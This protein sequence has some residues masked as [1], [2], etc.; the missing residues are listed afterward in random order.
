MNRQ[1]P[2]FLV[3]LIFPTMLTA[4]WVQLPGPYGGIVQAL[5]E[6]ADGTLLS[7]Q[8]AGPLYM[9]SDDGRNWSVVVKDSW[10]E[11]IVLFA[12]APNGTVFAGEYHGL[13]RSAD[14]RTW[15][16]LDLQDV[17]A[18]IAFATNED[19]LVGGIGAIHRSSDD[20][21]NWKTLTPIPAS[22][23]MFRI[24]VTGSGA[25]LAGAYRE[26]IL[27][28]TDEGG[29]WETTGASLPNNEVYSLSTVDGDI[30]F[31]GLNNTTWF[32]I[33]DGETWSE[34]S[35][36]V[37]VNVYR[38]W[39]LS[40]NRLGAGS[41]GGLFISADDGRN[42]VRS[43]GET[44]HNQLSA[45]HVTPAGLLLAAANGTVLRSTD[46]GDSWESSVEGIHVTDITA[47]CFPNDDVY[48]AGTMYCDIHRATDGGHT[49]HLADTV[50]RAFS[51]ADLIA[52]TRAVHAATIDMGFR[53]STDAGETW[54]TIPSP[55]ENFSGTALTETATGLLAA[56][57]DGTCFHTT[58]QGTSWE[59][60]GTIM[61]F[62][63]TVNRV[64]LLSDINEANRIYAGTDRGLYRSTDAGETWIRFPLPGA[65]TDILFLHQSPDASLF[66]WSGK[67]LFRSGDLGESWTEIYE[68][69]ELPW[70]PLITTN[71]R[72]NVFVTDAEGIAHSADGIDGWERLNVPHRIT[73]L[74]VDRDGYLLIGTESDGLYRSEETTVGIPDITSMPNGLHIDGVYPQPLRAGAAGTLRVTMKRDAVVTLQ[75]FD[76]LGNMVIEQS[77][78]R[79]AAGSQ[80]FSL[81]ADGLVPG[82]YTVRVTAGM[83][84]A[85]RKLLI[86]D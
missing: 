66:A 47:L 86:L 70:R 68:T 9:S 29:S 82:V 64:R 60:R 73:A 57:Y 34:A 46:H 18:S 85:E 2:F 62:S 21:D 51:T 45:V 15:E 23:R 39:R 55:E 74:A 84:R 80:G 17:P 48:L 49:W 81:N 72:G 31:A 42:W 65:S 83:E 20:G 7:A 44:I 59:Q 11:N 40:G 30:V 33:D 13:H 58:D 67:K 79:I 6:T 3:M 22:K 52:G 77:P 50:F 5:G 12:T 4:Q 78:R 1:I 36:L 41:S 76:I 27:R 54:T 75:L 43:A 25:W 37:G 38:V 14:G 69:A 35:G 24:T 63:G 26:G 8:Y 10:T 19:L 56:S 53:T 61:P 32:T 28:S 16:A 71:R